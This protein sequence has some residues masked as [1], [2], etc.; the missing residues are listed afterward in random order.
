M[1]SKTLLL[2]LIPGLLLAQKQ[3]SSIPVTPN[4]VEQKRQSPPPSPGLGTI[5]KLNPSSAAEEPLLPPEVSKSFSL[6]EHFFPHPGVVFLQGGKY[7]GDDHLYNLTNNIGVYIEIEKSKD[8]KIDIDKKKIKELIGFIFKKTILIPNV[9]DEKPP[10][11][12]FHLLIMVAPIGDKG[13][14]FYCS[15][16]LFESIKLD[17]IDMDKNMQFQA[18]TWEKQILLVVPADKLKDELY[19]AVREITTNFVERYRHFEDIKLRKTADP[20]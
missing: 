4:I 5:E 19:T 12:Y 15:G 10:F 18:I 3:N 9:K 17:R 7:A 1:I 11:P 13:Y 8:V 14:A 2:L 20:R 16:R 6:E